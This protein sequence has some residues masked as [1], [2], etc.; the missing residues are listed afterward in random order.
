MQIVAVPAGETVP[1]FIAKYQQSGLVEF[2]EP[3]Y[4]GHVAATPNDPYYTNGTLWGLNNIEA[5]AAWDVLTSASN[6]VVAVLDTGVR[7]TH[8]DLKSNMWVNPNDGGHGWNA[9]AGTN[10]PERR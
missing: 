6:I 7:Y 8:E 3:D 4:F 2:A 5:P 10:D 1:G 9:R